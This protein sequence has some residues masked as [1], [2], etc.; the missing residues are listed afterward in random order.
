MTWGF[1]LRGHGA[2]GQEDPIAGK[3]NDDGGTG[4]AVDS[5]AG[6]GEGAPPAPFR[7]VKSVLAVATNTTAANT[8]AA[9]AVV[10]AAA[11]A[12]LAAAAATMATA[13]AVAPLPP[14][15]VLSGRT[16][17]VLEDYSCGRPTELVPGRTLVQSHRI[18]EDVEEKLLA[19]ARTW[20]GG[21]LQGGG[22]DE[23]LV[24]GRV[25]TKRRT[26][27]WWLPRLPHHNQASLIT[28]M[29]SAFSTLIVVCC[30]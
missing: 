19:A 13:G 14:P 28:I 29:P 8:A 6:G 25:T 24:D 30:R 11:K 16:A 18:S 2:R 20:V 4:R 21:T 12:T 15:E 9:A 23:R 17:H 27:L 1:D 3:D 26:Q 10:K 7:R 22:A 5:S